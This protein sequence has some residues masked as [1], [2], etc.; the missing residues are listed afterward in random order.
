MD[1]L[2]G[3]AATYHHMGLLCTDMGEHER[4]VGYHRQALALR[5]RLRGEQ[6]IAEVLV[7]LAW[8][9]HQDPSTTLT[10]RAEA[11]RP[12]SEQALGRSQSDPR[13][14]EAR[15]DWD[16]MDA[17]V[18]RAWTLAERLGRDDL[19]TRLLWLKAEV[20]LAAGSAA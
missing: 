17:V 19:V 3:L 15:E 5:E 10:T 1:D 2:S 14:A 13:G 20:A 6:D 12:S 8:A 7:S 11:I 18:R 16:A 4:A 9:Y